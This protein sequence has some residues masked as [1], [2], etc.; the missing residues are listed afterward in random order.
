MHRVTR[1]GI[2]LAAVAA[3]AAPPALAAKSVYNA[4]LSGS[5]EVPARTT[6]ATG[7]ATLR[8]TQ[9]KSTIEYRIVVG[10][11]ENVIT[12]RLHLGPA[13]TEG[14]EIAT[15][16]GPTAPGAG[17]SSGVLVSGALAGANLV[18]PMAGKSIP[19]LIAAIEG[20]Q[21]Y[22]NLATDDGIGSPDERSGD[23]SS[24]EIR[25]QLK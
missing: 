23:F 17:K 4:R 20:G 15:L 2:T 3:L 25:G 16:Y 22:V 14:P 19:E 8:L 10:N 1:I 18:G 12:G 5:E 21:V 11:I 7:H 6:K 24:G 13:G 9:D